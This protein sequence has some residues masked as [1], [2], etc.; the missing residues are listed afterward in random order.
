MKV[1]PSQKRYLRWMTWCLIV[2][3]ALVYAAEWLRLEWLTIV[4]LAMLPVAFY[5][6]IAAHVRFTRM[7]KRHIL[8]QCIHCGYDATGSH[9]TGRCPECGRALSEK[10]DP[11]RNA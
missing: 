3:F 9:T 1:R 8:D 5:P 4:G 7:Q 6:V 10:L 11:R 2:A